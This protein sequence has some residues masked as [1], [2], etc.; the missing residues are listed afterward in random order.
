MIM[1]EIENVTITLLINF[2]LSWITYK[3]LLLFWHFYFLHRFNSSFSNFKLHTYNFTLTTLHLQT[4]NL[5]QQKALNQQKMP[6]TFNSAHELMLQAD[7]D[8]QVEI[9]GPNQVCSTEFRCEG[10]KPCIGAWFL[11]ANSVGVIVSNRGAAIANIGSAPNHHSGT[12]S[13][14]DLCVRN[15]AYMTNDLA[16][17][18]RTEERVY[19]NQ[20]P[21]GFIAAGTLYGMMGMSDQVIRIRRILESWR[22]EVTTETYPVSLTENALGAVFVDGRAGPRTIWINDKSY[23]LWEWRKILIIDHDNLIVDSLTIDL[24]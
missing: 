23:I 22:M 13:A 5:K 10:K 20:N 12:S 9:V 4:S 24:E 19:E 1:N 17:V 14:D 16:D 7:K 2:L 6:V 8:G 3:Y 11:N 15:A 21:R 18:L